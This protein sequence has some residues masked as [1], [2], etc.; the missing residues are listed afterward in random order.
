[1]EMLMRSWAHSLLSKNIL[2]HEIV[3]ILGEICCIF[4]IL[5]ALFP[6]TFSLFLLNFHYNFKNKN[7]HIY[8]FLKWV[9]LSDQ[10]FCT[11]DQLSIFMNRC[12]PINILEMPSLTGIDNCLHTDG[13]C[14]ALTI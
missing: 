1:M 11:Q 8:L 7:K 2:L 12:I 4:L 10:M 5:W 3:A 9:Y 13:S 14:R 6:D